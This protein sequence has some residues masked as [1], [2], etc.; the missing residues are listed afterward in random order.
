M[1]LEHLLFGED[2]KS[3]AIL[4]LASFIYLYRHTVRIALKRKFIDL[5][6][7]DNEVKKKVFCRG[8]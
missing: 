4:L 1:W 2:I 3:E 8:S 6:G 7:I 5:L